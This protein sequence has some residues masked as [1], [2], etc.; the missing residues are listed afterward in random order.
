MGGVV[1]GAWREEP[2]AIRQLAIERQSFHMRAANRQ[3]DIACREHR[4]LSR[5]WGWLHIRRT[6]RGRGLSMHGVG[7]RQQG[8]IARLRS[9]QGEPERQ[10]VAPEAGRYGD[11]RKGE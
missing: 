6:Q 3:G 2:A 5:R 10:S 9:D 1:W 11:S 7:Q 4:P 8:S